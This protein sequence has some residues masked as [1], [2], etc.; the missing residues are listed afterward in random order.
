MSKV[1]EV[2]RMDGGGLMGYWK[3][4]KWMD[5]PWVVRVDGKFLRNKVGDVRRFASE[6]G[7]RRALAKG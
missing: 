5:R 3:P 1:V 7:A 6:E 2:F 4:A